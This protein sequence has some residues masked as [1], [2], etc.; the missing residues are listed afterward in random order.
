MTKPTLEQTLEKFDEIWTSPIK[1]SFHLI[2]NMAF[3][4][5]LI[6]DGWELGRTALYEDTKKLAEECEDFE[7]FGT[8]LKEI[9]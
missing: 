3:S 7:T 2:E 5:Q 6:R 8:R 4:K 1:D 9:L